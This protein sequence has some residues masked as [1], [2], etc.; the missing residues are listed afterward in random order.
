MGPRVLCTVAALL[1]AGAI[2]G[3][4]LAGAG[5]ELTPTA[6]VSL[7]VPASN[8][9][10]P[11]NVPRSVTVPAGWRAE[12]WARV[13]GARFAVWSPEGELLVSSPATGSVIE[14]VPGSTPGAT[15]VQRTLV[16]GL[17]QPQGLAFDTVA[18]QQVLYVAEEDAIDRYS[19]HDGTIG[20]RSVLASALP[21]ADAARDDVHS[22]K[23]LAVGP[24][25]TIYVTVGSA[26]N[27]NAVDVERSPPRAAVWAYRPDG[28]GPRVAATGVRN[29]EGLAIAPD[30]TLWAA[31]NERDQ[32]PYPFHKA[33]GGYADAYGHVISSYV[34]DNPPDEL[35]RLTP[36]RNLGWPYCN[37]DVDVVPGDPARGQNYDRPRFDPDEQNNPGGT[38]F[39]CSK[40]TPIDRPL[41]AHDAPLGLTF[42]ATSSLPARWR[43]GA[44]LAIHGSSDLQPP[45]APAVLWLPWLRTRTLG[46]PIALL[47]GFQRGGRWGRPVDAVPGPD[48]AVYVTDDEANAI[49]RLT[50]PGVR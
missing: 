48:G 30:G 25:H 27:A 4:D 13:G 18:G 36:G 35:A 3:A 21:A 39:D 32:I 16:S 49:Y 22:L 8:A 42:L 6:T 10:A 2:A 38:R 41:P 29:G 43:A 47:G 24:D 31:V 26:N 19:W 17:D 50:P 14:L 12:V 44:L 1:C 45:R 34:D 11:F 15:P 40:L 28:S 5:S 9:F 20:T 37:P 23:G 7:G 33:Y 46:A